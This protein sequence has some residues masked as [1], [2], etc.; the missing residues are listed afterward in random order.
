ML[1][2]VLAVFALLLFGSAGDTLAQPGV[3]VQ[4]GTLGVVFAFAIP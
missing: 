2:P 3:E 4:A 1:I